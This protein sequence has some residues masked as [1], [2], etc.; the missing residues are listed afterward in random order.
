ME[1]EVN[2]YIKQGYRRYSISI[3]WGID[4]FT[5]D[6]STPSWNNSEIVNGLIRARYSQDRVE[7]II[8]NHFLNISEW[9]DKKFNGE[10]VKFEDPEY[11]KLQ[12]WR[13]QCKQWAKEAL[14]KYPP[15]Q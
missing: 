7:A 5:L 3:S 9:L 13:T 11:D 15:I 1:F 14:E 12:E 10:D 6:L 8:N 4:G 2:T